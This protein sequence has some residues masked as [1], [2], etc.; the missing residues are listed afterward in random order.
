[1]GSA[2]NLAASDHAATADADAAVVRRRLEVILTRVTRRAIGLASLMR[3]GPGSLPAN[4]P[5]GSGVAAGA[6]GPSL[7]VAELIDEKPAEHGPH[8]LFVKAGSPGHM[9]RLKA[10]AAGLKALATA[11]A[12]RV[13]QT[14]LVGGEGRSYFLVL[15]FLTLV[16]GTAQSFARLGH[17]LA[18]LHRPA[19]P[20]FGFARDNFIGATV[21]HNRLQDDWPAFFRDCRLVPQLALA[22]ANHLDAALLDAGARLLECLPAFFAGHMPQASL[23]HGDLWHGNAGFLAD[24]TPVLFD[25]AVYWGDREADLAMTELFGGFPASFY[26]AYREAAPLDPGYAVRKHLYNLYHVLNHANLQ[27]DWARGQR[28]AG[29]YGR[30][31]HGMIQQLLAETRP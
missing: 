14:W 4:G 2:F 16:P 15:E 21:Q 30:Q 31:A 17:A 3:I 25:P 7:F 6:Q 5:A 13:P 12:L 29:N 23:M 9:E 26:A 11:G 27:A 28:D 20:Q 22:K 18:E 8:R 19:Q 10:E 1:M 24:G